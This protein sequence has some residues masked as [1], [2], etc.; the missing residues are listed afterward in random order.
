MLLAILHV[1]SFC[2]SEDYCKE[3]GL[4]AKEDPSKAAQ[5]CKQGMIR[6][7]M[8]PKHHQHHKFIWSSLQGTILAIIVLAS[9]ICSCGKWYLL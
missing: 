9:I 7:H 2:W 6:A 1:C 3:P 8:L 4:V 5:S